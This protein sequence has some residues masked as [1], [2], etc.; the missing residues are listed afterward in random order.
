MPGRFQVSSCCKSC[1]SCRSTLGRTSQFPSPGRP[2]SAATQRLTLRPREFQPPSHRTFVA[3]L[4]G[5][6]S[7]GLALCVSRLRVRLCLLS[8]L[9]PSPTQRQSSC[10][11]SLEE[12]VPGSTLVCSVAGTDQS[13]SLDSSLHITLVSI[14]TLLLD[15]LTAGHTPPHEPARLSLSQL[16]PSPSNK[17]TIV[18]TACPSLPREDRLTSGNRSW[19]NHST[20]PPS[21]DRRPQ[22]LCS[23]GCAGIGPHQR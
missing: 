4:F 22:P 16:D 12:R 17:S 20:S 2:L 21:G 10:R 3:R 7:P 14:H 19:E 18:T 13:E 8:S 15:G 6:P 5:C 1:Q 9:A 11:L 23:G